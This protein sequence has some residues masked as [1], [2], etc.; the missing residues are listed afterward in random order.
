MGA[1][2]VARVTSWHLLATYTSWW[3]KARAGVGAGQAG[4]IEP[5]PCL[6]TGTK[7]LAASET[8]WLDMPYQGEGSTFTIN[9]SHLSCAH[10]FPSARRCG[11]TRGLAVRLL[12]AQD[13]H[14]WD[15]QQENTTALYL[16]A[17]VVDV[18]GWLH[19][20]PNSTPWPSEFPTARYL[21][22][23]HNTGRVPMGVQCAV[24]LLTP[25]CLAALYLFLAIQF[26]L[27]IGCL[28]CA[29]CCMGGTEQ[30]PASWPPPGCCHLPA[31]PFLACCCGQ[32]LISS[33]RAPRENLVDW[34]RSQLLWT[35]AWYP[36]FDE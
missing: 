22:A 26:P 19:N 6:W 12:M 13:R 34:W 17:D 10:A 25:N 30:P 8:W 29:D 20:L 5:D 4:C 9:V 27:F 36:A 24:T 28:L 14:T 15:P 3:E 16:A 23:L 2:L 1:A 35:Q 21:L 31:T 11:S 18:R 33:L 7:S 32:L